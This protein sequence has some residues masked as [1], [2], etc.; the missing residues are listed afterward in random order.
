MIPRSGTVTKDACQ[1]HLVKYKENGDIYL[2]GPNI[3]L[4]RVLDKQHTRVPGERRWIPKQNIFQKAI[5]AAVALTSKEVTSEVYAKRM[6]TCNG[7][8]KLDRIGDK[9]FCGACGCGRTQFSE[10]KHKNKFSKTQ[11]RLRKFES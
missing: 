10:L 4:E 3:A 8:E 11:C 5:S 9:I 7:C 2:D 1:V 6:E